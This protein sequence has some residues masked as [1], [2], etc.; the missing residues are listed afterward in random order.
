MLGTGLP[1]SK[2]KA[3]KASLPQAQRCARLRCMPTSAKRPK[4]SPKSPPSP[5]S[6]RPPAPKAVNQRVLQEMSL[7]Y[8]IEV[9]HAG[10]VT[11]AAARLD[12]APSAVSRQIARLERELDTLLF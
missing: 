4:V 1:C 10:S 3:L 8:F 2:H 9:V 6:Q 11:E 7:R 5:K 12:V